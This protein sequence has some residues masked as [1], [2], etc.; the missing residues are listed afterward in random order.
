M[1]LGFLLLSVWTVQETFCKSLNNVEQSIQA[2]KMFINKGNWDIRKVPTISSGPGAEE[3]E[4]I[5]NN[6][7][8][9]NGRVSM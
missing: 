1:F 7:G 3:S 6:P 4:M 2:D 8:L 5:Y 9:D